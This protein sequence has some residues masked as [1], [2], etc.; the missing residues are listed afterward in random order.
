MLRVLLAAV[1][2]G[3]TVFAWGFVTHT[4]TP[5]ASMGFR[6]LPEA[7]E[8]ELLRAIDGV[9][10]A[11]GQYF[12]PWMEPGSTPDPSSGPAAFLTYRR[13]VSYA[14][15]PQALGIEAA[16]NVAAALVLALV[17]VQ[18]LPQASFLRRVFASGLFGLF[19]AL[20]ISVSHW[21][22]FGFSQDF[23]IAEAIDQTG[24]WLAA[25]LVMAMILPRAEA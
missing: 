25:G 12:V 21:N 17:L 13:S 24:G 10:T 2:G 1:F 16:S 8:Q 7:S 20:S 3:L 5:L 22:W 9:L 23:L 18:L 11:E 4:Q 19:A 14:P 6:E 15:S